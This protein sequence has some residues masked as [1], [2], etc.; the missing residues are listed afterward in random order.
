MHSI[1]IVNQVFKKKRAVSV[2]HVGQRKT[3]LFAFLFMCVFPLMISCVL[4]EI[5]KSTVLVK[6]K[7][8]FPDVSKYT[9]VFD[10]SYGRLEMDLEAAIA[11]MLPA[12]ISADYEEEA[13]MAQAILLRTELLYHYANN[14]D[15]QY[16]I[17]LEKEPFVK[18]YLTFQEQK[19]IWNEN[20]RENIAVYKHAVMETAGMYIKNTNE[21]NNGEVEAGGWFLVS[22]GS[23]REGVVCEKDYK[24]TDYYNEKV[25]TKAEFCRVIREIYENEKFENHDKKIK[26]V[27]EIFFIDIE[28]EGYDKDITFELISERGERAEYIVSADKLCKEFH[29]ASAYIEEIT[30]SEYNVSITVKGVGH[31]SGMSLF[32]ANELAKEGKNYEEILNYFFTNIAIDKFE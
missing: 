5:N 11:C 2:A 10:T 16:Y 24:A 25:F 31:G 1:Q 26:Q 20:Y 22:A 17:Y 29:L 7:F 18:K 8:L 32:G 12:V 6:N 23:T 30:E 15:R 3:V 4:G 21:E 13:I 27:D 9:V 19:E 28:G 14:S